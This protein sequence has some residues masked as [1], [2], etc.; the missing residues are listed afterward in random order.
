MKTRIKNPPS[1]AVLIHIPIELLDRL[2]EA[3]TVLG[4]NRSELIRSALARDHAEKILPEIQNKNKRNKT[5][6]KKLSW[7]SWA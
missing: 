7:L 1:R 6:E 3:A 2:D 4:L 5:A